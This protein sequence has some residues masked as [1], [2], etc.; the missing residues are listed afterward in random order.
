MSVIE[1]VCRHWVGVVVEL[2]KNKNEE[3]EEVS[4]REDEEGVCW[5][6][7]AAVFLKKKLLC[8]RVLQRKKRTQ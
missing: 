7:K 8:R 6:T 2:A 4:T 1:G 3:E 5:C